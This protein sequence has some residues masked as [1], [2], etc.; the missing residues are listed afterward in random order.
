MK[1]KQY[2]LEKQAKLDILIDELY[3]LLKDYK[4]SKTTSDFWNRVNGFGPEEDEE[5]EGEL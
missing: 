4:E 5:D 2:E 3:E 1:Q